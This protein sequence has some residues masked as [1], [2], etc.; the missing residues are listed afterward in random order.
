MPAANFG[1]ANSVAG[2]CNLRLYFAVSSGFGGC[3]SV[4][5]LVFILYFQN[6]TQRHY[7]ANVTQHI[8][9]A[10]SPKRGMQPQQTL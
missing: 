3:N 8:S 6:F 5:L 1:I 9:T 7:R 4:K 10:E 2:C